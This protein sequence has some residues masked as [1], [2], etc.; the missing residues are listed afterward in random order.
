MLNVLN[1]V[2]LAR[3]RRLLLKDVQV[4]QLLQATQDPNYRVDWYQ[5]DEGHQVVIAYNRD[6]TLLSIEIRNNN[7]VICPWLGNFLTLDFSNCAD[8]FRYAT[9]L[10]EVIQ[11][12]CSFG[13]AFMME[14]ALGSPDLHLSIPISKWQAART[15][16]LQTLLSLKTEIAQ[17]LEREIRHYIEDQKD[18]QARVN[19]MAEFDPSESSED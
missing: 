10:C 2:L 1:C 9:G 12:R 13:N 16:V 7:V 15:G 17:N 14:N 19:E 3:L 11:D 4:L 18:Q 8:P 6:Q 5:F